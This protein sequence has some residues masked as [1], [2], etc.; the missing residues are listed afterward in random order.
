MYGLLIFFAKIQL[1]QND[2]TVGRLLLF[3]SFVI[4][5]NIN[6]SSKSQPDAL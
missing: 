6:N 3:C 4:N 1:F 2:R 5:L